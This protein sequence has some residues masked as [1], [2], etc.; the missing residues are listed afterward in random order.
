MRC[1]KNEVFPG[2][3][4]TT[5]SRLSP[6]ADFARRFN[7]L[8]IL[9]LFFFL[10]LI[11]IRVWNDQHYCLLGS[12][13]VYSLRFSVSSNLCARPFCGCTKRNKA[14]Q[15]CPNPDQRWRHSGGGKKKLPAVKRWKDPVCWSARPR[16]STCAAP[17][18]SCLRLGTFHSNNSILSW[19]SCY[20]H[21]DWWYDWSHVLL[22]CSRGPF[23]NVALHTFDWPTAS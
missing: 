7:P 9:F 15:Q 17:E 8:I 12:N 1:K 2:G 11:F 20:L 13:A 23:W 18:H 10:S 4:T 16:L 21:R 22:L 19:R 6:Q 5:S 14:N 3:L